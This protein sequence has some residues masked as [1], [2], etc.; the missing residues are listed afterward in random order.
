M[1]R[2]TWFDCLS[3]GGKAE[4]AQVN[5]QPYLAINHGS[6]SHC[7]KCCFTPEIVCWDEP[8]RSKQDPSNKANAII[9]RSAAVTTETQARWFHI[10]TQKSL[11]VTFGVS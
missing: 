4:L 11:F 9:S 6:C 7:S 8:W 2:D 3:S 5:M 10:H 1:L